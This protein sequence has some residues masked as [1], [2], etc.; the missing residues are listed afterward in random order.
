[1]FQQ[2]SLDC[3]NFWP[4]VGSCNSNA[5]KYKLAENGVFPSAVASCSRQAQME[6]FWWLSLPCFC[7]LPPSLPKGTVTLLQPPREK[8]DEVAH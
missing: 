6:V 1:M 2:T 4:L 7:F 8:H 3:N 5:V